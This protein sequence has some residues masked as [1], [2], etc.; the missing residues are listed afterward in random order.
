MLSNPEDRESRKFTDEEKANILQKQ[1]ASV[2]THVPILTSRTNSR[3]ADYT[4]TVDMCDQGRTSRLGTPLSRGGGA[5]VEKPEGPSALQL[6]TNHQY[7]KINW[8]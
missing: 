2:F 8:T 7:K 3:I 5:G 4:F 6:T 1:F